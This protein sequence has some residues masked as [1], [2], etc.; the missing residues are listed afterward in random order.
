MSAQ[1]LRTEIL[2]LLTDVRLA[3]RGASRPSFEAVID[4]RIPRLVSAHDPFEGASLSDNALAAIRNA[5]SAACEQN[6]SEPRRAGIG[7][8]FLP[9]R[10]GLAGAAALV[11]IL[12]ALYTF[13]PSGN[14]N[15]ATR[16]QERAAPRVVVGTLRPLIGSP[17]LRGPGAGAPISVNEKVEIVLG[18]RI[19]TDDM[20]KAEIIQKD[21]STFVLD[22]NT[23]VEF[24][25]RSAAGHILGR[26]LVLING[27]VFA[28]VAPTKDRQKFAIQ[29]PVATAEVL[30]TEFTLAVRKIRAAGHGVR[31]TL[32]VKS[33]RVKF[34]NEFGDVVAPDMTESTAVAGAAPTEP[35]RLRFLRVALR[36][37]R[38]SAQG[39]RRTFPMKPG[40]AAENF[41]PRNAT[42]LTVSTLPGGDLGIVGLAENS[43]A[44]AAGLRV[45]DVIAALDGRRN[46]S[47]SAI[48]GAIYLRAG[49]SLRLT[50]R[51]NGAQSEIAVP[52]RPDSPAIP[53]RLTRLLVDATAPALSGDSDK[54]IRRLTMLARRVPH[55]AVYHNLGVVYERL[56]RM[57]PTIQ[58][59]QAAVRL[60]PGAA[61]Y[62]RSL[63]RAL[64]KIENLNRTVEELEAAMA[65]KAG[66]P[67][68]VPLLADAYLLVDRT[69]EALALV[70]SALRLDPKNARVWVAKTRVLMRAAK[71]EEANEAAFQATRQAPD[72][73]EAHSTLAGI[74]AF[75][76]HGEEAD[77]AYRKAIELDPC[78]WRFY[79]YRADNLRG[80]GRTR[81]AEAANRLAAQVGRDD[82]LA[83]TAYGVR[84]LRTAR[85]GEA[86]P[87]L[88]RALELDPEDP[89]AYYNLG[90][91]MEGL[92]RLR[93][94]ANLFEKA[95][96]LFPNDDR[97]WS[98]LGR[99]LIALGELGR[100]EAALAEALRRKPAG[101]THDWQIGDVVTHSD[102]IPSNPGN[103]VGNVTWTS[104]IRGAINISGACWRV[105][106]LGRS[107]D[108]KLFHN[109]RLLSYGTVHSGD[110]YTRANPF[111]FRDGSGGSA[112]LN[113]RT[114]A[115]GDIIKLEIVQN[116]QSY[117]GD[118]IGV[119]LTI[120]T[121]PDSRVFDLAADWSDTDNPNGVWSY[122]EGTNALPHVAAWDSIVFDYWSG[123]QPAWADSEHGRP[124]MPSW[125]K[126]SA[127]TFRDET[128]SNWA[129]IL[130]HKGV[131][132]N[133]ALRR[134]KKAVGPNAPA[135]RF[136]VLGF[137]HFKRGE[138]D[139]AI[140][141]LKRAAADLSKSYVAADAQVV[142]GQ[143]YERKKD[144]PAAIDAY[145][146][147]LKIEPA[148][149][150][151]ADA[152]KRLAP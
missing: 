65:D 76:G 134:A 112:V 98:Y 82:P 152:L 31:A 20:D 7:F 21:G 78:Q 87:F 11:L 57:G 61:L 64:H 6:P 128:S 85:A 80:M 115:P 106:D 97:A 36:Y 100:A 12:I 72:S 113:G 84:L 66:H 68:T 94:A 16:P 114:V 45:G 132:L 14:Q 96:K 73:A 25:N 92:G 107:Q 32:R 74:L 54:A 103:G 33:G 46:P 143:V 50:V 13:R 71:P 62:R 35:R 86:E 140:E 138:F 139:Q 38:S 104:P 109:N 131:K 28:K 79:H 150:S 53:P 124:R 41:V 89:D 137:V 120:R 37:G 148:N 116:P 67:E 77:M 10:W 102:D 88:R 123:P 26:D 69:R 17:K 93:E 48:R 146:R 119:A 110:P 136:Y 2:G 127:G 52:V 51:R 56:D 58:S 70:E 43:P 147:A 9:W 95:V 29:T 8:S 30:G 121:L 105:R 144:I 91:T 117:N 49:Q 90:Q 108:W 111:R 135:S 129:L 1:G 142:L 149:R 19:E 81:E 39:Y 59:Y 141:P 4:R 22:F 63:A 44:R 27:N 83:Q 60:D 99:P 23:T 47:E 75:R 145:R 118:M 3:G 15:V 101:E 34:Y 5:V 24:R 151:A 130:A 18:A 42:G 40:E 126:L 133:E 122:N 55:A 125:F